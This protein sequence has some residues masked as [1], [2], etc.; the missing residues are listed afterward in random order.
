[1]LANRKAI[2]VFVYLLSEFAWV[3][4]LLL[5]ATPSSFI[6]GV[7]PNVTLGC[8]PQ[9]LDS[10]GL[11]DIA[12]IQLVKDNVLLVTGRPTGADLADTRPRFCAQSHIDPGDLPHAYL[13]L[14]ILY[15]DEGDLGQYTCLMTY[16]D[17]VGLSQRAE[18]RLTLQ[19]TDTG[20]SSVQ[21]QLE[22]ALQQL[23]NLQARVRSLEDGVLG[24]ARD[25]GNNS[26][27]IADLRQTVT[28]HIAFFAS[29]V[30]RQP[31]QK[32]DVVVFDRTV[33]NIG[34]GYNPT[35]GIFSAPKAGFYIFNVVCEVKIA[36]MFRME[37]LLVVDGVAAMKLYIVGETQAQ[38]GQQAGSLVYQLNKGS[39]VK[40]QVGVIQAGPGLP[41]DLAS[42]NLT[43]FSGYFLG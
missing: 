6:A 23:G 20:N 8:V 7:T 22:N 42:E 29:L 19:L 41:A 43:C 5:T 15:P 12:V 1:M 28:S 24:L 13:T 2:F 36:D 4:L 33:F 39:Q 34:G 17:N 38:G 21:V 37:M 10:A 40:V 30:N 14:T 31:I 3:H 35:T 32:D 25:S 9:D 16:F 18:A 11:T 27:L 26:L